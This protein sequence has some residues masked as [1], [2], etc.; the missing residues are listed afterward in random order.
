MLFALA[1]TTH[2]SSSTGSTTTPR[3]TRSPMTAA[4][5]CTTTRA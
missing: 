3:G 4:E 5:A 1:C 2:M